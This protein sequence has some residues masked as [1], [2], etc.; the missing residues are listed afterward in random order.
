MIYVCS[1]LNLFEILL[2]YYKMMLV[3]RYSSV[4]YCIH[5]GAGQTSHF[6]DLYRDLIVFCVPHAH[7]LR[8]IPVNHMFIKPAFPKLILTLPTEIIN[9]TSGPAESGLWSTTNFDINLSKNILI[10]SF[11]SFYPHIVKWPYKTGRWYIPRRKRVA[12]AKVT[13]IYN[14]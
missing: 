12:S 10:S 9:F 6:Q 4:C 8:Y 3:I 2:S 13:C 1:M 5:C 7:T 11:R 14:V